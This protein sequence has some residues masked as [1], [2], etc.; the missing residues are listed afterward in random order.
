MTV[1][2][3]L[4]LLCAFSCTLSAQEV[5]I[6]T[7][8]PGAE[9]LDF[10]LPATDGKTYSLDDFQEHPV[11][12]ILFTCN[13]CPTAQAYEDKIIK[14]VNEYEPRGVRLVAISPNDPNAVSLSEL[15]YS[16]V[17]DS[18][19]DMKIRAREKNFSFPYLFDG[20][21]QAT[22][23]AY[24]PMAT[25]HAFVFDEKRILR[26]SGRIDDTEDPYVLPLTNDLRNA[27]DAILAGNKV[28]VSSTKTFGCSIK[29]GWKK[30]WIA[31][32]KEE[33]TN[34]PVTL[35]EVD[36]DGVKAL[37]SNQTDKLLLLNVW[38]TWC[39]PCVMELP[40]F[41]EINRMYRGRDFEMVTISTDKLFQKQKA[42]DMLK[43]IEAS[44][45]NFI[46]SGIQIYDLIEVIDEDWSGA[47]PYTL[48]IEP[49]GK[50]HQRIAGTID[51]QRVK[52]EVVEYLGRYY[53]DNK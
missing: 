3:L 20:E 10:S 16:D 19:D 34:E 1:K 5:E 23:V 14:L 25:P 53:A 32:Q 30:D 29:W 44:N 6:K 43:K 11:L 38:A 42:F 50:V 49:G 26:Y 4:W 27:I 21:T 37:V 47:L 35:E 41:I 51:P 24:G 17:G 28:D 36:I 7:L 45:R 46:Y 12:V 52:K 33:W 22:S 18:M 40:S 31:K 15:G 48:L 8:Q 39:G 2:K 13:H 9:A